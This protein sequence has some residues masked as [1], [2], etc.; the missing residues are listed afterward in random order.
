[1]DNV[2]L[3]KRVV[4]QTGT[5]VDGIGPDQLAG[6]TPCAEWSVRDVINHITGGAMMFAECVDQGSVPDDRLGQLMAGDNLGDD[7]K[8]AFHAAADRAVTSFDAP[9]AL[10]KM[11]KLPF[12]E[13]PAG[14]A[15]NIA[16][17]DVTTHAC[18]L[19][20]ATG[21]SVDDQELLETALAVGQQMIGPEMRQPGV[22][23]PEQPAPEGASAADRLLAFAGRQLT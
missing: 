2:A 9:G 19:A 18:D 23:G 14:I 6:P 4:A 21:Q 10:D 16:V 7:Y 5:V 11:V 8:G 20:R 1:M 22:F 17:F 3:M 15:L 12:G 13:M